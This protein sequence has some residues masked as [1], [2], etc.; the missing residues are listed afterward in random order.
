MS[1]HRR[2]LEQL[3]DVAVTAAHPRPVVDEAVAR[4]RD[5]TAIPRRLTVIAIGKAAPEMATAAVSAL[6]PLGLRI[7]NGI[8][9]G[10]DEDL[11][12]HSAIRRVAGDHPMPGARSRAAARLVGDVARAAHSSSDAVLVLISGGATSLV[13]APVEGIDGD[14]LA[15]LN[16][17][18][19]R[20]GWDITAMNTVRKRF[21]R[22]GAGRL[23]AA[24]AP[25]PLHL[26]ILSDVIGDDPG[27]IASG[28]CA[29]DPTRA[30]DILERLKQLP[31]LPASAGT[32]LAAHLADVMRGRIPETP[33][34]GDPV[35]DRVGAPLVRGNSAALAAMEEHARRAGWTASVNPAPLRGEARERGVEIAHELLAAS[36]DR[37]CLI[38]G[39]ETTVT[40]A[41]PAEG[42]G[43]RCQELALAAAQVLAG[44][45]RDTR[46]IT[47]LASGTDGRDGPTDAAGAIVD[48]ETWHRSAANGGAPEDA[49]TG[50]DSYRALSASG[51]LLPA[52]TTGTNVMDVV[53]GLVSDD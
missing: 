28:P 40:M 33:K 34:P 5:E 35:F 38:R 7:V 52:R 13:G 50:H 18:L 29:P 26:S 49:I 48:R 17:A 16:A 36:H 9:V 39:G 31:D 32:L 42:L 46:S 11:A 12:P 20:S 30:G 37:V 21:M 3:Y 47:L 1:A 15:A 51:A 24:L 19:L 43:G 6:E 4:L 44:A 25:I 27:I 22:W 14:A 10:V 2:F 45:P 53:V 41:P 8:I 23:A